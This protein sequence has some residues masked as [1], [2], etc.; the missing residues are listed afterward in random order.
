MNAFKLNEGDQRRAI[1]NNKVLP[2]NTLHAFRLEINSYLTQNAESIP[3][4]TQASSRMR[5]TN[6]NRKISS[7]N[8]I[9]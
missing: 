1:I 3:T 6:A 4:H 2:I 9:S 8:G 7:N 5:E